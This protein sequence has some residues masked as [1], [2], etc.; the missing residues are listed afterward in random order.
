[1]DGVVA[2]TSPSTS[3]IQATK[4]LPLKNPYQNLLVQGIVY[5]LV[6]ITSST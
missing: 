1:M 4:Y 5:N 3:K 2:H 6:L